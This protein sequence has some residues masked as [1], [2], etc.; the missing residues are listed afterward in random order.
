M[1]RI[2]KTT[3]SDAMYAA[4]QEQ[5]IAEGQ[6]GFPGGPTHIVRKAVRYWLVKSGRGASDIDRTDA[7]YRHDQQI[8]GDRLPGTCEGTPEDG[9][10]ADFQE[11]R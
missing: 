2:I 6:C 9:A 5:S 4:L 3:L 1:S 8:A 10:D 11:I 7:E